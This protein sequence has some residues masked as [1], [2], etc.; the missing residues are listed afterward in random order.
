MPTPAKTAKPSSNVAARIAGDNVHL[1]L[2][3]SALERIKA[4]T[5]APLQFVVVGNTIQILVGSD[6]SLTHEMPVVSADDVA[7]QFIAVA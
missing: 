2:P 4:K 7:D 6:K 3:K 1:T 5:G